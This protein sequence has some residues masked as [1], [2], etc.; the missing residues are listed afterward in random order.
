M[1]IHFN[2]NHLIATV[3]NVD[4]ADFEYYLEKGT[5][6]TKVLTRLGVEPNLVSSVGGLKLA[7]TAD[8]INEV[9]ANKAIKSCMTKE[10]VGKF[11][12]ANG[13]AV[14][15]T[16]AFRVLVGINGQ[17][18][19]PRGYGYQNTSVYPLIKDY[20]QPDV[21]EGPGSTFVDHKANFTRV[22]GTQ[23]VID[24]VLVEIT[25]AE[26]KASIEEH[27]LFDWW[28]PVWLN[29]IPD[30]AQPGYVLHLPDRGCKVKLLEVRR[31]EI[32]NTITYEGVIKRPVLVRPE[33]AFVPYLDFEAECKNFYSSYDPAYYHDWQ[34]WEEWDEELTNLLTFNHDNRSQL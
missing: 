12:E 10:P 11:Y 33:G 7:T 3:C 16:K 22:D 4:V 8:E 13:I 23:E 26:G 18:I 30:Q 27:N 32:L 19:A 2:V 20:F 9:Y 24:S 5:K 1:K 21:Y 14:L 34:G 31:T 28:G 17:G 15:H 6:P 25:N 29:R